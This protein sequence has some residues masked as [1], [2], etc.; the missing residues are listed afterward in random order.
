MGSESEH[1]SDIEMLD[2]MTLTEHAPRG[3]KRVH[4]EDERDD[5]SDGITEIPNPLAGPSTE[6]YSKKPKGSTSSQP[7]TWS[8]TRSTTAA[9]NTQLKKKRKV[10]SDKGKEKQ[11]DATP[12]RRPSRPPAASVPPSPQKNSQSEDPENPSLNI[13][14]PK[15]ASGRAESAVVKLFFTQVSKSNPTGTRYCKVCEKIREF[16]PDHAVAEYAQTT[17]NDILRRHLKNCHPKAYQQM[18]DIQVFLDTGTQPDSQKTLDGHLQKIA[19]KIPFSAE[20]LAKALVKLIAACD[21]PLSFVDQP[22]FEEVVRV[23]KPD[24]KSSDLTELS[25][26]AAEFDNSVKA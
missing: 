26:S 21:L 11:R 24:I 2:P 14:L 5:E 16:S 23:L 6:Q 1:E 9:V 8:K 13:P 17:S 20:R 19:S 7:T 4:S 18:L 22:E 15:K 3:R 25:N 10:A 12:P